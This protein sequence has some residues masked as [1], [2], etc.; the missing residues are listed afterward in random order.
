MGVTIEEAKKLDHFVCAECSSD[1]DIKKP[2][3]TFSSSPGSDSKVNLQFF[4][5]FVLIIC[6][7]QHMSELVV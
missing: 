4:Y 3:T 5:T 1:D 2:Q 7:S 6:F